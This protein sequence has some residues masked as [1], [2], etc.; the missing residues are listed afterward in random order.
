MIKRLRHFPEVTDF[1]DFLLVKKWKISS[2][3]LKIR[4]QIEVTLY[5]IP[6][7]WTVPLDRHSVQSQENERSAKYFFPPN[8]SKKSVQI[9]SLVNSENKLYKTTLRVRCIQR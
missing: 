5:K 9:R 8:E 4:S 7:Y 1:D 3:F 2:C 6:E